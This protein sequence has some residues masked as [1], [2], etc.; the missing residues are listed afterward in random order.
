MNSLFGNVYLICCCC[1]FFS[2][3]KPGCSDELTPSRKDS[4]VAGAIESLKCLDEIMDKKDIANLH[5]NDQENEH[6]TCDTENEVPSVDMIYNEDKD[7]I[8]SHLNPECLQRNADKTEERDLSTTAFVEQLTTEN[9]EYAKQEEEV[10][11]VDNEPDI[12]QDNDDN[13]SLSSSENEIVESMDQL[14]VNMSI[15]GDNEDFHTESVSNDVSKKDGT[16]QDGERDSLAVKDETISSADEIPSNDGTSQ[17]GERDNLAVKDENISSANDIPRDNSKGL[18]T[19][20]NERTSVAVNSSSN[21]LGEHLLETKTSENVTDHL[22]VDQN[23]TIETKIS[24]NEQNV[25]DFAHKRENEAEEKTEINEQISNEPETDSEEEHEYDSE[26]AD[27]TLTLQPS[28]HPSPGESSVMSCLS[29]FCAPELLDGNNKFACEECS[30]RAQRSENKK[31]SNVN[32]N[33]GSAN[34]KDS[35]S[36]DGK[37]QSCLQGHL[38]WSGVEP[39][40][41]FNSSVISL[42]FNW[43]VLWL[44]KKV[45]LH[46]F[47]SLRKQSTFC[48]A[49]T[50]FPAK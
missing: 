36:D 29:Q 14:T 32:G 49:N 11:L 24:A 21:E 28:Y 22:T 35:D 13:Q 34:D 31:G 1:C 48:D 12:K 33:E 18:T 4:Q 8:S 20:V 15:K 3:I 44:K 30:K 41:D 46:F 26:E 17:D 23:N 47:F 42:G 43:F 6:E 38:T 37:Y 25:S 50:G 45:S 40:V 9:T 7:T 27:S 10:R 16:S 39:T 19:T 5:E 2:D